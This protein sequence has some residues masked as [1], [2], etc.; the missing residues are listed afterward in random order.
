MVR[1]SSAALLLLS[2]GLLAALG[3]ESTPAPP[4]VALESSLTAQ[5]KKS[6]GF[7]QCPTLG[8]WLQIGEFRGPTKD[9][10][11]VVIDGEAQE[12]LTVSLECSVAPSGAGFDVNVLAQ[13]EGNEGG[14][15]TITGN[16]S[17][18]GEQDNVTAVFQRAE[19]G[20][21]T[22]TGCKVSYFAPGEA[23]TDADGKPI[24]SFRGVA[25]GR[26]WGFLTCDAAE[27]VQSNK[28]CK[29]TAQFRFEN[30]GKGE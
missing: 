1:Q 14:S 3:C 22:A 17:A 25:A 9:E 19:Y 12:D 23:T 11:S 20:N 21:F 8:S 24:K 28:A 5:S 26:V 10:T 13:L 15:V 4:Q 29:A 7:D 2:L 18:D 30:C 27:N 16:F 6:D